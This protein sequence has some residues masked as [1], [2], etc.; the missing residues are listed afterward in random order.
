MGHHW[1]KGRFFHVLG[2]SDKGRAVSILAEFYRK[3]YGPLTTVALGDSLNDL[4]MLNG[5]D[6]PIVVRKAVRSYGSGLELPIFF[7]NVFLLLTLMP[8]L[9]IAALGENPVAERYLYLPSA[10]FAM[11]AGFF[12]SRVANRVGKGTISAVLAVILTLACIGTVG[13]AG[14][15]RDNYTFWSDAVRKSPDNATVHRYYGYSLYTRNRIPE[16]IREYEKSLS[17]D[18]KNIETHFNL[19][20][21]YQVEG[22]FDD[23]IREYKIVLQSRP[24]DSAPVLTNLGEAL[25]SKGD[26]GSAFLSCEAAVQRDANLAEAHSCLGTLYGNT[27]MLDKAIAE[28]E[29]ASNLNPDNLNYKRNLALA[30]RMSIH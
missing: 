12:L 8:A 13:R 10:G 11:L 14:V 18:D 28:F 1:T 17:V 9:D 29:Q 6:I 30:K 24:L 15:W 21:A 19:G 7:A 3:A 20:A 23:A 25:A 4:P 22:R 16:A 26:V 27:G 2:N 5:V